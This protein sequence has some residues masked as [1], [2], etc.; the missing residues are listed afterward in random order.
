MKKPLFIL[1]ILIFISGCA[2]RDIPAWRLASF[3]HLESYKKS[4]LEGRTELAQ[5]Y[6]QKA[7][8]EIKKGGD[9]E[10]LA[11]AHLTR[12]AL[13]VAVL[14][15]P[16]EDD[17]RGVEA[18]WPMPANANYLLLL[19]GDFSRVDKSLLPVQYQEFLTS[20]RGI[21]EGQLDGILGGIADPLS[22]LVALGLAV[23][24]LNAN[25]NILL[26]A[27]ETSSR[28]GWKRPLLVYLSALKTFYESRREME[29]ARLV[30][31]RLMLIR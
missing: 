8:E 1:S 14:E 9:L 6:F 19:K 10:V 27:V 20:A 7:L 31:R 25:E 5:V 28:Q 3:N 23:R 24:H 16:P 4:F 2:V 30:E 12:S 18:A 15:Q 21:S 26:T 13:A 11:R 29:K 22:R 17:Y